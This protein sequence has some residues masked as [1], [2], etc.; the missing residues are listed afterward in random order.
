M[1]HTRI[2]IVSFALLL[3]CANGAQGGFIDWIRAD[4]ETVPTPS[5]QQTQATWDQVGVATSSTALTIPLTLTAAGTTA[6][7]TATLGG[8]SNGWESRGGTAQ[9]R[10]QVTGT[11]M[12]DL[13][14]DLVAMRD[15]AATLALTGLTV[16]RQYSLSAWHNDSFTGGTPGFA[17]GGGNVIPTV[18]GGIID[19]ATN[20]LLQNLFG[21]QTD[22]AFSPTELLFTAT[23]TNA[24]VFFTSSNPNGFLPFNAIQFAAAELPPPAP[25]P[26]TGCLALAG[27]FFLRRKSRSGRRSE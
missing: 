5:N 27:L 12:N 24:T 21:A 6:G 10:G 4:L 22:A 23:N 7:I 16:G 13:V 15:G 11:S 8:D 2:S 20:G 9:Q 19:A 1:N 25:E 26:A 14:E 3:V 18:T 17:N